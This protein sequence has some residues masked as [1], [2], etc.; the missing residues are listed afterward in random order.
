MAT[1]PS[2]TLNPVKSMTYNPICAEA[3]CGEPDAGTVPGLSA[4]TGVVLS[5]RM[6]TRR[7][8]SPQER[9]M[10]RMEGRVRVLVFL[11][12]SGE[13]VSHLSVPLIYTSEKYKM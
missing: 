10:D 7:R 13:M 8:T 5:T 11:F 6:R 1:V 4:R 9:T 2:D 12:W 3:G